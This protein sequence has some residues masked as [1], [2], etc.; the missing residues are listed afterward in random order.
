MPNILTRFIDQK[1]C[2][3]VLAWRNDYTTRKMSLCSKRIS[4]QV[5]NDWFAAMLSSNNHEGIIGELS[6]S[7][8]GVVFFKNEGLISKV[9]INLNPRYRGKRLSAA[10]LHDAIQTFNELPHEKNYFVAEIQQGNSA[11]IR[12]FIKNGFELETLENEI[13]T[14]RLPLVETVGE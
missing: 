10:L 5:H 14:Y 9:S 3:D 13:G 2:F 1:D 11:S 7:K 4:V 12:T 6:G 8:F